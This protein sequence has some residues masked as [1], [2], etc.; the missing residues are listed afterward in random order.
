MNHIRQNNCSNCKN[1]KEPPKKRSKRQRKKRTMAPSNV[2][3]QAAVSHG[4]GPL[5]GL[6]QIE[7]GAD[8]VG[9]I[10][11]DRAAEV[12]HGEPARSDEFHQ[13]FF[14]M[15]NDGTN[16]T[17]AAAAAATGTRVATGSAIAT[18]ATSARGG[19]AGTAQ[20]GVEVHQ[21]LGGDALEDNTGHEK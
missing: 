7:G 14:M 13:R 5:S 4:V 11:V 9:V 12:M 8:D 1:P 16:A 19:G 15:G 2:V 3:I 10:A 20:Q 18:A 6:Q 17:A 21:R